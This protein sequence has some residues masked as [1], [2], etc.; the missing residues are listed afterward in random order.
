ML[1]ADQTA[2]VAQA[3]AAGPGSRH[4]TLLVAAIKIAG[5]VAAGWI[6]E[7]EARAALTIAAAGYIGVAGYTARQVERDISDGFSYAATTTRPT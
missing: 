7:A 4:R 5:L 6:A 3:G 2:R 1:L